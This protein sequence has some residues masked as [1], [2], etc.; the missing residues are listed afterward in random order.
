MENFDRFWRYLYNKSEPSEEREKKKRDEKHEE[1]NTGRRRGRTP[2][3]SIERVVLYY[4]TDRRISMTPSFSSLSPSPTPN[5]QRSFVL[6]S[7]RH[8]F[9]QSNKPAVTSQDS[10]SSEP[11][12]D[13]VV[14]IAAQKSPAPPESSVASKPVRNS[15]P[16]AAVRKPP[17]SS[18]DSMSV[19]LSS[20]PIGDIVVPTVRRPPNGSNPEKSMLQR[21]LDH[22]IVIYESEEPTSSKEEAAA[23]AMKVESE[24]HASTGQGERPE[25]ESSS[26]AERNLFFQLDELS[27]SDEPEEGRV[28]VKSHVYEVNLL[29]SPLTPENRL[30]DQS[31]STADLPHVV[32]RRQGR[33]DEAVAYKKAQSDKSTVTTPP[34]DVQVHSTKKQMLDQAT[35]TT[36]HSP[37][38]PTVVFED[39]PETDV[40]LPDFKDQ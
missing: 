39:A 17:V 23:E 22:G 27:G 2:T 8:L 32:R 37:T 6:D 35:S 33:D 18:Q 34:L 9:I 40:S 3:P 28:D 12:G 11:L 1:R 30:T 16:A 4:T 26:A 15:A 19:S 20:E 24:T 13:I 29:P 7:G 14:P 21:T 38:P 5:S 10:L 36:S 25:S 31:T